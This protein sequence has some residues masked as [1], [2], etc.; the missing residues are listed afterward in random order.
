MCFLQDI[1]KGRQKSR[2]EIVI[3][4][5]CVT[6]NRVNLSRCE[7]EYSVCHVKP[8]KLRR[9]KSERP[10][11]SL[12]I[13]LWATLPIVSLTQSQKLVAF[14]AMCVLTC[15]VVFSFPYMT[16][17]FML[18]QSHM[19]AEI[20]KLKPWTS[21]ISNLSR[22]PLTVQA[23]VPFLFVSPIEQSLSSTYH[24]FPIRK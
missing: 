19:T 12:Q 3:S 17:V 1:N 22:E 21:R 5:L 4:Y 20:T 10:G 9:L 15:W 7:N 18:A 24:D 11:Y 2:K 14:M 16:A 13:S 6:A 8:L 23:F